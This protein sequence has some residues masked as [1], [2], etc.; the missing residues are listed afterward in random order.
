MYSSSSTSS[1]TL[2]LREVRFIVV[3]SL[4]YKLM[5]FT[6]LLIPIENEKNQKTTSYGSGSGRLS[7][8]RILVVVLS[9]CVCDFPVL[10]E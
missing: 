10:W 5:W 2:A 9:A 1:D 7:K 4:E 6:I 3:T 8:K